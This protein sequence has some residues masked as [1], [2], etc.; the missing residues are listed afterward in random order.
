MSVVHT[1]SAFNLPLGYNDNRVILLARDPHLLFAYW[2]ISEEKKNEFI[3]EFGHELWEKSTPFLKVT[4][5]SCNISFYIRIN[6]FSNN[7]YINVEDSN[8]LYVAELGRRISD[9]F[10][11]NLASSNYINTPNDAVSTNVAGHFIN[12][13]TLKNGTLDVNSGK[14]YETYEYKLQ[15]K[16]IFGVSSQ[17]LFGINFKESLFG[18]SSA[19]LFGINLTEH[20]GISSQSFIR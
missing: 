4:N 16:A 14:I 20:L 12:Y 1:K 19:E 17:E 5:V 6:D 11:I 10:F 13:N 15:T 8:C 9:K 7:W 3:G 2:E 18:V